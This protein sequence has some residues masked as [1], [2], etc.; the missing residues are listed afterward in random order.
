MN[1]IEKLI[2]KLCP[3][4][5]EFKALHT[6]TH[7]GRGKRLTKRE[8]DSTG[9]GFPVYSGGVTPMGYYGEYNQPANTVT[10]V[11]YGTAGFVNY[12]SQK[13]W[14]N[15]VC[16]CIKSRDETCLQN[17]FLYYTLKNRQLQI[18]SL[19]I[20]AIPAHLPTD[21]IKNFLIPVPPLE[22]QQEIVNILD[23]FSELKLEL[24]AELEARRKQYQY[25]RDELL[26][27]S[28]ALSSIHNQI[29]LTSSDKVPIKELG[30]IGKLVRGNGI[31]K[32]D[33]T[34][35]GT[36][37][38]HYGQIHTHY[39]VHASKTKS[40]IDPSLATH[41]RK[42]QKGDLVIATTSE[43]DSGVAKAVA[44]IGDENIAV[45]TDAYI[46]S[47]SL[48]PKY[49]SYFFQTEIFHKQKKCHITGTKVRR[50]S[51]KRLAKIKIPV[52]PLEVQNG[53]V[54]ILDN[55]DA[56]VND[57]S[58]G[59]PAEIVA[60]RKQYEYYREKLLTFKEAP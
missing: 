24:N 37:C 22:I 53:I 33:F 16:Y 38:I 47:H 48:N 59:I 2:A 44:W 42:A 3:S 8:L 39:G 18:Q 20:D 14:A 5:V 26:N 46:L 10:V 49:L 52:P 41:L 34:D 19:V 43:D 32:S 58:I 13:F 15:D 40:F 25:Y 35:H 55:F 31:Q 51:G 50:I 54:S 30:E 21:S 27:F 45:S 11:K 4:G 12:I 23:T 60:R 9:R 29:G 7:V 17:K 36:G 28:G 56:L 1:K 6:I 57:L